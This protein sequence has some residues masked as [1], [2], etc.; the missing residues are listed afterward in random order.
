VP[1]YCKILKILHFFWHFFWH[2]DRKQRFFA[3]TFGGRL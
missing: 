3:P 1:E 2:F